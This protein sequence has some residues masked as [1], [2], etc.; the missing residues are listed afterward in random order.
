MVGWIL[1]A[2]LTQFKSYRASNTAT[3][4]VRVML[5][6]S[7]KVVSLL[8]LKVASCNAVFTSLPQAL[9]LTV[10]LLG[11]AAGRLRWYI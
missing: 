5:M 1:A 11:N 2:F 8:I 7:F 3:K 4:R 9:N 6:P 10:S